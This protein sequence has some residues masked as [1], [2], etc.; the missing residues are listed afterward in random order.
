MSVWAWGA[1]YLLEG[2]ITVYVLCLMARLNDENAPLREGIFFVMLWP[3]FWVLLL[4]G[5]IAFGAQDRREARVRQILTAVKQG[6]ATDEEIAVFA[7]LRQNQARAIVAELSGQ[8]RLTRVQEE[9]WALP[10]QE[11][12]RASQH[13]VAPV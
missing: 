2:I 13:R 10:P 7:G 1:L 11:R 3:L 4:L 6:A 12:A 5:A 9:R 8:G